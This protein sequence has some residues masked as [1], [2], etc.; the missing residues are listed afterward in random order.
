[1]QSSFR[2]YADYA[3]TISGASHCCKYILLLGHFFRGRN[4]SDPNMTIGNFVTIIVA[5]QLR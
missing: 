1:M 2:E 5:A 3:P 4:G